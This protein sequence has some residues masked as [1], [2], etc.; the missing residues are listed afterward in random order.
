MSIARK[1]EQGGLLAALFVRRPVLAVVINALICV[2]GLAALIAVEVRELPSVEQPVL[3]VSTSF[4]G[5]AAETVDRE[6]TAVVE[7][8]VARVQGVAGIS[9]QSSTGQS[10]V[11]LEFTEGT[12]LDT[13]T[14]D[15]RDALSRIGRSLPDAADDPVIFKADADAQAIIQLAVTSSRHTT[16]ELSQIVE[17][18][19][20]ERLASVPGVAEVQVYGTRQ[21]AFEIDVDPLKLASLGLTVADVRNAVATLAFDTPAGSINGPN[22][23]I[24]V[25][26]VSELTRPED[27]ESIQITN[28]VR[29]RDVATVVFDASGLDQFPALRRPARHRPRHHPTGAVE[30]HLDLARHRRRRRNPQPDPARRRSRA[31]F[32]R[33]GGVHRGRAARGCRSRWSPRSSSSSAS[34]SSSCATGAPPSCR[35]SPCRSPCSAP[36]PA[37]TPSASRSTS[38]PCSPWSSPPASSSTTPLSSS[39]TSS[40]ASSSAPARARRPC[41]ARRRCSSPSSPPRSPSSPS[42]CRSPSSAGNPGACSASSASRLPSRSCCPR[43]S[44]CRSGRCSPR[45]CCARATSPKSGPTRCSRASAPGSPGSTAS[46]CAGRSPTL[47][48]SS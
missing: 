40:G 14:S 1:N 24:S 2:A 48:S 35:P 37:S 42:S 38:S 4:T 39:R 7:G 9:S 17:D 47:S 13:A 30:Q 11:T 20:S 32:E 31:R 6:V 25:R 22:Q 27:F 21:T 3:S 45:G 43:W 28:Q 12:N 46:P 41:S 23:N 10:R 15:V 44:R 19:I 16:A 33:R 18:V 8:A 36:S 5:A 34:S 26:A 29:L